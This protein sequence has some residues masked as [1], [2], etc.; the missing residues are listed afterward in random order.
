MRF[1]QTTVGNILVATVLEN[2]IVADVA[3]RFKL[4]LMEYVNSG[5]RVIVLDMRAV[6]FIDSSGLG[7]L[8]SSLKAIGHNGDLV[9][10]GTAGAVNSMFKLT[11]MDKVFRMFSTPEEAVSA[12]AG[13]SLSREI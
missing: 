2:R 1:E 4:Q 9:L 8:V 11:R 12:L 3:P 7:A 13:N 6:S 5:N 10:C